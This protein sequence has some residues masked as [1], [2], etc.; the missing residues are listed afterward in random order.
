MQ[1]R[2]VRRGERECPRGGRGPVAIGPVAA[3]RKDGRGGPCHL[4]ARKPD[5][6]VPHRRS[7]PRATLCH[8]AQAL[9]QARQGEEPLSKVEELIM[10]LPTI[11]PAEARRLLDSGA[12][13]IDIREADE[14]AR[15]KIPGA[16]HLPLSRLDEADLAVHQG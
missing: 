5:A 13:L 16:R 1:A 11:N 4:P 10:S 8:A 15:E 6:L 12:L 7:A 9:L 2:R 3:P 14:H